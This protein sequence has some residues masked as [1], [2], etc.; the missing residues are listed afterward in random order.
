MIHFSC[1][2]RMP[3][4]EWLE[5]VII[6]RMPLHL[7]MPTTLKVVGFPCGTRTLKLFVQVRI[8][9]GAMLCMLDLGA[10]AAGMGRGA[11]AQRRRRPQG[12]ATALLLP[13]TDP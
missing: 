3:I 13:G 9:V 7:P 1:I 4:A 10:P 11:G 8:A 2:I 5:A 12:A 6:L